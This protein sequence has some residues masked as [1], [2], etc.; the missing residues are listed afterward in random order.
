MEFF[1]IVF[2]FFL[3]PSLSEG[4]KFFFKINPYNDKKKLFIEVLTLFFRDCGVS[5]Q[6]PNVKILDFYDTIS[7]IRA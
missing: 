4:L 5:Q 7:V 2:I 1:I 3:N 6:D